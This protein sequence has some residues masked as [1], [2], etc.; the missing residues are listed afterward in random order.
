MLTLEAG[1][2]WTGWKLSSHIFAESIFVEPSCGLVMGRPVLL[3]FEDC[4]S[5]CYHVHY[6][7]TDY[8]NKTVAVL[9]MKAVIYGAKSG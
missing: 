5:I 8:C 2:H 3:S 4:L 7:F 6:P 1:L 9:T